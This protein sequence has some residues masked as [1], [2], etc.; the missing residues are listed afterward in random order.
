MLL[1]KDK[2]IIFKS[3][4]IGD[5]INFSPCLKIIKDNKSKS[6]I[7]LVCSVY[8][9]Q[10]AKNY[11]KYIDKYIILKNKNFIINLIYHFKNFIMTNYK[12]LFQLDAN[13]NSYYLSSLITSEHKSTI[14][15]I[16]NKKIIGFKYRVYRPTLSLLKNKFTNYIFCDEDYSKNFHYQSLYLK[17]FKRLK[18]KITSKKKFFF[19]K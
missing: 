16:K 7:T 17:L 4:K 10:I 6:H 14:C 1:N 19:I 13:S 12:Y 18:F 15:F 8:N 11:N 3:D 9:Y 2:I 5:F